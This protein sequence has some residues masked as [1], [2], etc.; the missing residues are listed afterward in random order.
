MSYMERRYRKNHYHYHY[1]SLLTLAF[2]T[3]DRHL[4]NDFNPASDPSTTFDLDLLFSLKL[5]HPLPF[6]QYLQSVLYKL[7]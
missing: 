4:G 7:E 6:Q 2:S 3:S 1:Y 5:H